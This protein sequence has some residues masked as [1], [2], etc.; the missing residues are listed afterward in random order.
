MNWYKG[1]Y[2]ISD[3]K[4]LIDVAFVHQLLS[5]T[6]WA[7]DRT[8][9]TIQ[10]S[11]ENSLAFGLYNENKQIGFA[12]V[13]TDTVVFSWVL[14]VA[15]LES[16]RGSGLGKWLI[17]C[18]LEHPDIKNTNIALATKD[19]HDFYRSFQFDLSECMRRPKSS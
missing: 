15:I 16:Y 8:I 12:R 10:K 9:E 13:V 2:V 19:A 4:D 17:S 7:A 14:D 18:L 3:N 1:N 5:N 11:I 6:Y